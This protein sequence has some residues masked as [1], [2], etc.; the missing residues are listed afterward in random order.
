MTHNKRFWLFACIVVSTNLVGMSTPVPASGLAFQ[1]DTATAPNAIDPALAAKIDHLLKIFVSDDNKDEAAADTEIR[2]ILTQHVL[3]TVAQVGEWRATGFVVLAFNEFEPTFR[4]QLLGKVKDAVAR[5]QLPSYMFT[6]CETRAR[7]DNVKQA[8]TKRAPSNPELRDQIESLIKGDQA[9]RQ[10]E[11]FET[12]KVQEMDQQN[13]A[14]LLAIL[15]KYGVPTYAMVGPKAAG[16]FVLMLQ[17]QSPEFRQQELPGLKAN[18][19]AG[20][21]DP[22]AYAMAYDRTQRD[23]GN[24]QLY[25]MALECNA[26]ERLHEA[27]IEDEAH[28]NPRRAELGLMPVELYAYITEKIM[29][30]QFCPPGTTG[31]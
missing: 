25:G 29:P 23:L 24:K 14:L 1:S 4:K 30:K 28:V 19:D 2:K 10:K 11:G 17:H 13:A 20:Q 8:A 18:V 3:P 21:A 15:K 22:E 16:D 5:H 7:L 9:V 26:G 12:K 31:K 27:P 6:F